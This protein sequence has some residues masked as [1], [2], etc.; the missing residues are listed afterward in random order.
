[1][2]T[3]L[4]NTF[5]NYMVL[6]YWFYLHD[7]AKLRSL[8]VPFLVEGDDGLF[9]TDV[10]PNP[11]WFAKLGLI[12]KIVGADTVEDTDFCHIACACDGSLLRDPVEVFSKFGW[13]SAAPTGRRVTRNRLLKA[14]CFSGL[15]ECPS[16]PILSIYFKTLLEAVLPHKLKSVFVVDAYHQVLN[17]DTTDV[18][19]FI[20]THYQEPTQLGRELFERRYGFSISQQLEIERAIAQLDFSFL[21]CLS[22]RDKGEANDHLDYISKYIEVY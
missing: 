21:E 12:A 14:K 22:P 4:G 20:S 11:A 6:R 15:Y 8:D 13:T 10:H 2:C 3:A 16:C 17:T 7:P 1:M 18:T 9:V 19:K 5:A